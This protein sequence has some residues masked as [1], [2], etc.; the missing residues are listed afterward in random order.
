[1]TGKKFSREQPDEIKLLADALNNRAVSLLDLNHEQE[2][3]H[4]LRKALQS[5][6]HHP[7]AMYNTGLLEWSKTGN[8]DYEL[9]IKLEEVAKTPEY[10]GRGAN[11]LGRCL[12]R[13]GD[14][15]RALTSL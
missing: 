10:V 9:V 6:P 4:A 12:L 13:L 11:L 14:T 5:D 1:M 7:E 8:P 15:N 2:A 3:E